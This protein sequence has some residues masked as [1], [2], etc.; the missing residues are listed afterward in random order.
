MAG[1]GLRRA[2]PVIGS[3]L[4]PDGSSGHQTTRSQGVRA[5]SGHVYRL[6]EMSAAGQ[7]DESGHVDRAATSNIIETL[8]VTEMVFCPLSVG[9]GL[10]CQKWSLNA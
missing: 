5:I 3:L 4:M 1:D 2:A 9:V 7:W 8:A 6:R 10:L